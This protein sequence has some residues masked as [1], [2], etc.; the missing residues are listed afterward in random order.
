M[1]EN[2]F[3]VGFLLLLTVFIGL[4]VRSSRLKRAEQRQLE[5]KKRQIAAFATP[6]DSHMQKSSPPPGMPERRSGQDRRSGRDRRQAVR[7]VED[8]RKGPG[9]RKEDRVWAGKDYPGEE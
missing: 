5:R 8:R 2:I 9:R 4:V 1:I 6:T 3:I 7:F